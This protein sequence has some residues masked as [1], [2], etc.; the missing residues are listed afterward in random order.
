MTIALCLLLFVTGAVPLWYAWRANRQTSLL[1]AVNWA[2]TAWTVWGLSVA[3]SGTVP[4]W[5]LRYL[6]LSLTGC[7]AVAV[8]GARRPG[9]M[10]WNF[11]VL[12][13]L[14][15]HLLPVA[16]GAVTGSRLQ[17]DRFRIVF[18]SMTVAVGILNY[19]PTRLAAAT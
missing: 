18:L 16:E 11:V 2:V 3:A 4:G 17:F 19:L 6:A 10:A 12:G 7:A 5:L 9:V 14:A 13:L 15:V 8:L 1:Q